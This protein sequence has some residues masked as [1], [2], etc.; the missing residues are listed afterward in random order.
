MGT[1]V[2][3]LQEAVDK[4]VMVMKAKIN[5]GGTIPV[6]AMLQ[7]LMQLCGVTEAR[8]PLLNVAFRCH[9]LEFCRD[10]GYRDD[11]VG[12]DEKTAKDCVER[13][14]DNDLFFPRFAAHEEDDPPVLSIL[15]KEKVY[16]LVEQWMGGE[17]SALYINLLAVSPDELSCEIT[18]KCECYTTDEDDR[19]HVKSFSLSQAKKIAASTHLE[20]S[21]IIE[22]EAYKD[23]KTF[24]QDGGSEED[25]SE[26]ARKRQK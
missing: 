9:F 18:E 17:N 20:F 15:L 25:E 8:D 10:L 6:S 23:L 22:Q 16:K 12:L 26:Q 7:V 2:H 13:F 11:E 24:L 19:I 3:M 21:K 14:L 1:R 5:A 4:V